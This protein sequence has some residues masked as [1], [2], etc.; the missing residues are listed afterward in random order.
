VA[1]EGDAEVTKRLVALVLMS[2]LVFA[3]CGGDKKDEEASSGD[4]PQ[5]SE[6]SAAADVPDLPADFPLPGEVTLTGSTTAGPSTIIEGYFQAD[7]EEAFPEYKDAFVNA[8]WDIT[9]DEKEADDA[10][11]FFAHGNT[12]GQVNMFG[13]CQGRTKL[14]ITIRPS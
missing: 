12:N 14:R 3:A 6:A 1:T 9:K 2:V 5:C 7:I 10:E 8:G 11:I 4:R 13:E